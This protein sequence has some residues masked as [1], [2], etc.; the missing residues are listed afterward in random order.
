[1]PGKTDEDG[2]PGAVVVFS[3]LE[4]CGDVVIDSLEVEFRAFTFVWLKIKLANPQ[5]LHGLG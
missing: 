1:M 3:I 2:S 5:F 4:D